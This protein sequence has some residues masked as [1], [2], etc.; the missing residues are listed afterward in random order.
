MFS[1]KNILNVLV[2]SIIIRN[3]DFC[4]TS[5][6][7]HANIHPLLE[8]YGMIA[9]IT[10]SLHELLIELVCGLSFLCSSSLTFLLRLRL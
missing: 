8:T 9:M 10:W 4:A 3:R 1:S 6:T 7:F 5:W 2:R